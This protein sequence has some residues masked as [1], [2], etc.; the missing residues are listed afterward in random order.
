[1]SKKI[2]KSFL[3]IS[4]SWLK[5]K[6]DKKLYYGLTLFTI[7][8]CVL[9]AYAYSI[10]AIG[11]P[12][13]S[14]IQTYFQNLFSNWTN[15]PIT[16]PAVNPAP[17][18]PITP[19]PI[20]ITSTEYISNRLGISFYYTPFIS[21]PRAKEGGQRFFVREIGNTIYIY[22]KAWNSQG[23]EGS[24][25]QFLSEIAPDSKYVEVF[26]KDPQQSLAK[27]I[28]QYIFKGPIPYQCYINTSTQ[29][30]DPRIDESYQR[31]VI[32]EY[33]SQKILS[34]QE[35]RNYVLSCTSYAG[36]YIGKSYFM[37]DPNHPNKFLYIQLGQDDIPSG[38]KG[39]MWD[40]TIR[41]YPYPTG[42]PVPPTS[43][44]GPTP[45]AQLPNENFNKLAITETRGPKTLFTKV[46]NDKTAI[47]KLYDDIENLQ[48]WPP[49]HWIIN[50][51]MDNGTTIALDF[52]SNDTI[53]IQ[54]LY[55]TTGC[56]G[57]SITNY[58]GRNA[59]GS[60]GN[61]FNAD[62]SALMN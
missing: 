55:R 26:Y 59:M 30:G 43:T 36:N 2:K 9:V 61:K 53:T 22:Q 34:Y 62:L 56:R 18:I 23:Y 20:T 35:N 10:P 58:Q 33:P 11:V 41:S 6:I 38:Y 27:A 5:R 37:M 32:W 49:G 60:Q 39:Y 57:V 29:Y 3:K 12:L 17:I 47:N 48:H 14:Q 13:E 45:I 44:P 7:L 21:N 1:M 4:S 28:D 16:L 51:P 15:P 31:A 52:Y 19:P 25:Q 40:G 54:A 50:C 46:T 8:L 42:T 24:D